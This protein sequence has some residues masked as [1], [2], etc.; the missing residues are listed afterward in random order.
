MVLS[1]I[2]VLAG[3]VE[4]VDPARP[5]G[6]NVDQGEPRSLE[7]PDDGRSAP[8]SAQL[9][10]RFARARFRIIATVSA[11]PEGVRREIPELAEKGGAF[12]STDLRQPGLPVGQLILA[13][14][15]D[16]VAF[17]HYRIGG[18]VASQRIALIGKPLP[19]IYGTSCTFTLN[20][21]AAD[22]PTLKAVVA[23]H[24]GLMDGGCSAKEIMKQLRM[25][26]EK[27]ER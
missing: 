3:P 6:V 19:S 16:D 1:C 20:R 4:A 26:R 12:D 21:W 17:V 24:A 9:L 14:D 8:T 2:G 15:S 23:K 5:T 25:L 22:L 10:E 27:L 7:V 13:G 18:F 11:L